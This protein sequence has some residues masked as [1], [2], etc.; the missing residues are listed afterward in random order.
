MWE[1]LDKTFDTFDAEER[2]VD[3]LGSREGHNRKAYIDFLKGIGI[4]LV[5][6]G[7]GQIPEHLAAWIYSFHMPLFMFLSGLV[8]KEKYATAKEFVLQKVKQLLYPYFILGTLIIVYNSLFDFLRGK[9]QLVKLGKRILA[10]L[11]GNYIW[12]NNADYIGTL[13]FLV[14]LFCVEI[15]FWFIL[16]KSRNS[17]QTTFFVG[18][19]TVL[20][21]VLSYLINQS[22]QY[23][24]YGSGIRLPFCVDIAF[25]SLLFYYLGYSVHTIAVNKQI[26]GNYKYLG[27]VLFALGSIAA[28]V[29][30]SLTSTRI[31][32]LYLRLNTPILFYFSAILILLGI[33]LIASSNENFISKSFEIV[34][35]IGKKSL[36][37]M[38]IHLYTSVYVTYLLNAIGLNFPVA[39]IL[40]NIAISYLLASIVEKYF[41]FLYKFKR[42]AQKAIR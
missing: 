17:K 8:Y 20:G 34:I 12:E 1:L 30:H 18:C 22:R 31:D 35:S 42:S 39:Q 4:I 40:L 5:I 32:M 14:C 13:W 41:P 21:V 27:I 24:Y 26:R 23:T 2:N 37:M 15:F 16:K 9:F 33:Y 36:L 11:Y 29:N 10:L 28:M 6:C 38:V 25:C 3:T 19:L 7:H